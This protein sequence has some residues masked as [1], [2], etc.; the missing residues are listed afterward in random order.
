[1]SLARGSALTLGTVLLAAGLYFLYKQHGF[2]RLSNFP[3]GNAR[4]Q[5]TV[6]LGVFGVNGWTGELTA[7]A[8]G[9]LLLGAA[10]HVVARAMSL[11]VG[12]ALAAAAIIA[13]ISGNVLGLAAAN[14]WTKLGWGVAAVILLAGALLPYLRRARTRTIVAAPAAPVPPAA[15]ARRADGAR[16]GPITGR[17]QAAPM[18][19]EPVTT[20]REE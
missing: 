15:A 17:D 11:I 16:N 18:E 5:G 4:V 6:F 7:I 8:G 12:V 2:T 14:R 1:V 3:N 20:P 13:L 9:L 19:R 10:H